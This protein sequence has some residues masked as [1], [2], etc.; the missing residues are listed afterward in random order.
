MTGG[1]LIALGKA[2]PQMGLRNPLALRRHQ[3][4]GLAIGGEDDENL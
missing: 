4:N 1:G 2:L 3:A